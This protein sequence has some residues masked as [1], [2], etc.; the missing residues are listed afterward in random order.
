MTNERVSN[1][2]GCYWQN[3]AKCGWKDK[4]E[5]LKRC[6][7]LKKMAIILI[8]PKRK[9]GKNSDRRIDKEQYEMFPSFFD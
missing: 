7:L 1:S 2:F 5:T 6:L 9:G 8:D 4:G 3:Q